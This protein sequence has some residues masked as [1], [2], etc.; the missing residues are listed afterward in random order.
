MGLGAG[1][2]VYRADYPTPGARCV[3]G[4]IHVTDSVRDHLDALH[5][6]RAGGESSVLNCGYGKG[7][8]VLEVVDA[9][10]RVSGV[11]FPVKTVERR[12][13]DPP[14]L[15]A[16]AGRIHGMLG[17]E[18]RLNDLDTIVGHALAWEWHLKSKRDPALGIA[19][20]FGVGLA[21]S[22]S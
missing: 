19:C 8:S 20:A 9:V 12:P 21:F 6:L 3:R 16:G 17:W 5:Y 7:L 11:D 18:P 1:L 22:K 15:I 4:D 14:S 2:D 10:K 13:G